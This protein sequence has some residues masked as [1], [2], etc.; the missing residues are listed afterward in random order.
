MIS[1]MSLSCVNNSGET[2][3]PRKILKDFRVSHVTHYGMSS[4]SIDP[5][6]VFSSSHEAEDLITNVGE[7]L[8]DAAANCSRCSS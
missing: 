3:V 7:N 5:G 2:V 8:E 1:I 4:G 6:Y